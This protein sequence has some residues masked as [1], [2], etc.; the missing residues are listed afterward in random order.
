MSDDFTVTR[1]Q[2]SL[3]P[4]IATISMAAG[5]TRTWKDAQRVRR[6]NRIEGKR[7][8]KKGRA[9]EKKY[10]KL[11]SGREN[12]TKDQHNV[13]GINVDVLL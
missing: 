10:M 12:N 11:A 2:N 13:P 6:D 1:A 8:N 9:S 3:A 5:S 4:P 7:E